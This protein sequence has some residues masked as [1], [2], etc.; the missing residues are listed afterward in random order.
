MGIGDIDR[1]SIELTNRCS[2]ACW[3]CYNASGPDAATAWRADEVIA[4]ALDCAG[5]GVK[6]V[7]FGGGEPLEYAGL[8]D[9]LDALRGRIFRSLTTNGLHLDA[10]FDALVR[11]APDKVHVSIHAPGNAAEVGRVIGQV[12]ALAR[13]GLGSGVN[14]LVR[15]SQLPEAAAAAERV[16]A[17]GIG[18]ERIVYLPMRGQDTPTADELGRVAGSRRFQSMSC[19]L[20][21]ARSPRFVSIGWDKHV[22][23]CSYTR[24]RRPLA[25]PTHAAL[26]AALGGLGLDPCAEPRVERGP[27]RLPLAE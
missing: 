14:L 25:Q 10:C 18:N 12:D 1:I 7:S 5:H 17:A 2:K 20:A 8:F 3:F 19:L 22:A 23:W 27:R 15:A 21:C 6:A 9:V 4:L 13:A 26:L 11:A 24:S 16:R